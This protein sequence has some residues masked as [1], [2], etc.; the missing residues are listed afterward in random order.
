MRMALGW[1]VVVSLLAVASA[2][3]TGRQTTGESGVKVTPITSEG[4]QI[5]S[6]PS[7]SLA[8]PGRTRAP[9]VA[10]DLRGFVYPIVGA[11]LPTGDQLMPNAPRPYRNGFHEGVDFYDSDNCTRI[12]RGTPVVA[13]KAGTVIRADLDYKDLSSEELRQLEVN[14]TTD[15]A[16]DKF[17]GR[18]VWIQ[19]DG[20]IITRYDHLAGIAAGI[21]KSVR[22]KQGQVL[23]YVGESGT[24]E[25]VTA[26]GTEYHL[27]FEVWVNGSFLGKSISPAE[28]RRLYQA[29]FSQ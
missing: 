25:S 10:G 6:T 16:L 18:Q 23:A 11:C 12:G 28:V 29:L 20:G 21:A 7:S 9:S 2:A 15:E 27:Q 8:S 17:R 19:H 14:P 5:G 3:C 4:T 26:P 13:A 24:P 1:I 22:V